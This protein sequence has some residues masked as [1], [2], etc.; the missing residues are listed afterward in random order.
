MRCA[1]IVSILLLLA[2]CGGGRHSVRGGAPEQPG[3]GIQAG[4]QPP[5]NPEAGSVRV[6]LSAEQDG[7]DWRVNLIAPDASDLYQ[8]GGTLAFDSTKYEV[9]TVEAGG[10]LGQPENSYFV[11]RETSPGRVAF[12]YTKRFYG[13][14]A[15]GKLW[16]VSLR[17]HPKGSFSA[18][19]F[20]LDENQKLMARDSKKRVMHVE[21]GSAQ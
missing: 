18:A 1:L 15:S 20:K 5:A 19:D 8:I 12:A 13:A 6:S 17:V 21:A 14:G 16:L 9:L 3:G 7:S 2:S 10:G 4:G 11:G